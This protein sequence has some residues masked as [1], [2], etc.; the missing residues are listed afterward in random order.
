MKQVIIA[1]NMYNEIHQLDC[2]DSWFENVSHI[3]EGVLIV[4]TGS[5]DGTKEYFEEKA[6]KHKGKVVYITDDIILREG[7]GPARNHLREMCR[8]HFPNSHWC[9]YLDADERMDLEERH[10]FRFL[11]DYLV[12][13]YDVIAFP[14]LNRLNKHNKETKV[15][16]HIHPDFQSRMSRLSSRLR[17]IRKLH[18]QVVDAV[19]IYALITNPKIHHFHRST[20]QAKRDYIG[21]MCA[22]LHMEDDEYGHTYPEHHKE[23][24]YRELLEKEGL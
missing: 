6:E 21:K 13:R 17:Y 23:A 19:G 9:F 8:K 11:K 4:D 24:H 16:Y 20:D 7:Y 12:E 2:E 3:A 14:R 1:S 22:K 10:T 15:D 5:D 18:E